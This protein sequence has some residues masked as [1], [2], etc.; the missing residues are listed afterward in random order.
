MQ[1]KNIKKPLNEK[2]IEIMGKIQDSPIYFV[3]L[4][5]G[6]VPQ[7]LKKEYQTQFKIGRVL[8][9]K[10]WNQ[11]TKSIAVNWFE[12]FV[13]GKHITW[14][15]WVILLSIEKALQ[16]K[17][18]KKLSIIS[19]RGIGKSSVLAL[20]ILWFIFAFPLSLVASTAVTSDQLEEA[21]WKELAVWRDK[22]PSEYK[23]VFILTKKHLRR[24]EA[25]AK[26]YARARTAT[27]DRP[28]ALSGVHAEWIM[29]IIDEASAVHEKVFEMGQGILTSENAFMVMISNGTVNTGYFYRSHNENSASYQCLSFDS[30]QSPIVNKAYIQSIIDEYCV[31]IPPE[32]YHTVTEYRVNVLGL[33]P[34]IGLM[35][36]KGFIPLLDERDIIEE[37]GEYKFV[38][39]RI[40]AVDPAGD[41]DDT[42][43]WA[44]RDRVRINIL[45]EEQTSTPASIGSK[46]ITLAESIDIS[47]EEYR[48]IIIDAF[49]VGHSVS[50]EI[51]IITK[52]KG[53]TY[54]VN[55][56]EPCEYE[57]DRDLYVNQRAE[58]YWKMRTWLK[59]GGSIGIHPGFKKE[60][61][62]IRYRR[63][64]GRIQIES[65]LDMKK[66]GIKSPNLSDSASLTFLRDINLHPISRK[67][68]NRI[69]AMA[70]KFDPNSIFGE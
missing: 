14:Q 39:H 33:F 56:G 28:E 26:W 49:G 48:D 1:T 22:L 8:E 20:I 52:G 40:L 41:G 10:Q 23:R 54:P 13:K 45:H 51:A 46:T 58:A 68:T 60:L 61:L 25:P 53:R 59:H 70:E 9:G 5:F 15:Q 12:P 36:E 17:A 50:Q 24:R 67:E 7:P 64:G 32:Q 27:K 6:L 2:E 69:R 57:E 34:K 63:V 19:G 31:N 29:A 11:F 65:K 55:I 18:S 4:M 42:S 47:V 38:G 66:R 37:G 3:E 35:D 44:G 62:S 30:S 16:G 43:S 21:M